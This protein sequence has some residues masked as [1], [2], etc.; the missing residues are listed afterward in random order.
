MQLPNADLAIVDPEK[1]RAYCLNKDHPRGKHKARV[2]ESVL[3]ITAEDTENLIIQIK[4]RIQ[5]AACEAQEGDAYG[6]RYTVD[7]EIENFASKA[8]VRTAWIIRRGE[9]QPRLTT[10]YVK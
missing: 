8:T 7:I 9:M 10:C 4:E 5:E 6:Q 3:G 1:L 2:F